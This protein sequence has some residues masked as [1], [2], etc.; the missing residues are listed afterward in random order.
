MSDTMAS[1]RITV[2]VPRT[3]TARLRSRSRAKGTTESELVREAL[4]N[5]LGHSA[6]ERS[7]YEL[8][9]E[10]GIIGCLRGAPRDLSTN[11]RHLRGLAKADE[12]GSGRYR[13]DRRYPESQ[14]SVSPSV[15]RR[16][17]SST[18]ASVYLLASY[19]RSRLAPTP[20]PERGAPTGQ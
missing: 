3:L 20:Q 14:R 17:P 9:E 1:N 10:A 18:W 16:A 19:H 2:R 13:P 4:E 12:A 6:E 7:A 5:Y 15:R 8:A 11:T